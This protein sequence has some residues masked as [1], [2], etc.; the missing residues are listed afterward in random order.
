V[1]LSRLSKRIA[2]PG[3]LICL[4][5][6]LCSCVGPQNADTMAYQIISPNASWKYYDDELVVFGVNIDAG[7]VR[8]VSS[9]DGPIGYGSCVTK[10]LSPGIHAITACVDGVVQSCDITVTHH[11]YGNGDEISIGLNNYH[12]ER[13]IPQAAYYPYAVSCGVGVSDLRISSTTLMET[14][15]YQGV[16]LDPVRDFR[17]NARV[18]N[19]LLRE[20]R[21]VTRA[22]EIKTLGD[23]RSFRVINT[24]KP[25]EDP[26]N[27]TASLVYISGNIYA[28]LGTGS[29]DN[30]E[31]IKTVCA[32]VDRIVIPRVKS[33]WGQ[34]GDIDGNGHINILFVKSI[35]DEGIAIGFFNPS[36]FYGYNGDVNSDSYN[37]TSNEMDILYL[38]V[39]EDDPT[40]AYTNKVIA[41]TVAHELTHAVTFTRKTWNRQIAGDLDAPQEELFLDEGWSH[42]SESLCGYGASGGNLKFLNAY[43]A[44][45]SRF[46]L[47][48]KNAHGQDDSAGRRGGMALF[49]YWLFQKRGGMTWDGSDSINPIDNGGIGFLRTMTESPSTG[50]ESIGLAYGSTTRALFLAFAKDMNV[51]RSD[52]SPVGSIF[53]PVTAEPITISE[54]MG[55]ITVGDVSIEIGSA[56]SFNAPIANNVDVIPWSFELFSPLT[57]T[58]AQDLVI[59]QSTSNAD[60]FLKFL[61]H[62][63]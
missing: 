50:W 6:A 7:S 24:A 47:C 19:L 21:A 44:D 46:S 43:L 55:T 58:S 17:V 35:N 34:W 62:S 60:A 51:L 25:Y 45:T 13:R 31:A 14:Q 49:L 38:A 63:Q 52:N 53:D 39:P 20:S 22:S 42:L 56:K 61:I 1:C 27:V 12:T 4:T 9:I 5:V 3:L 18:G 16:S 2:L 37:P 41:A 48:E 28:W 33:I 8:W 59:M 15:S 11:A 30:S 29:G 10:Y 57:F 54:N 36:D 23:T 32:E 40:S 26:Q